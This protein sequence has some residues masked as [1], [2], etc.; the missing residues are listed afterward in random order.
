MNAP[1]SA[2]QLPPEPKIEPQ[3]SWFRRVM[4]YVRDLFLHMS[5]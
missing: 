5:A 4:N 2:R 1:K 3:A